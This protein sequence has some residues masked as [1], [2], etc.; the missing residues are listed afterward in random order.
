MTKSMKYP[1]QVYNYTEVEEYIIIFYIVF[2]VAAL[3]P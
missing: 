3:S 2:F 1:A